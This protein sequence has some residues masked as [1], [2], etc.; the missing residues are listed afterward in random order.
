[1]KNIGFFGVAEATTLIGE[2]TLA[3]AVGF[4]M[5]SGKSF[6]PVPQAVLAGSWAVGAGRLLVLGDHVI[7][8]GGVDG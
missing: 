5:V 3:P 8:T 1:M 7:G 4:E 6:D 2:V